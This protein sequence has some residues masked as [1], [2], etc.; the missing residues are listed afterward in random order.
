MADPADHALQGVDHIA[1]ATRD[2]ARSL[3]FFRDRLGLVVVHDETLE[4][5][6]VRLVMLEGGGTQIQLVQPMGPG[7]VAA[8]LD[9]SGE[10]LHH[11]CFRVRRIEDSVAALG[12]AI[13]G[14][15][16]IGAHG[17]PSCFLDEPASGTVVELTELAARALPS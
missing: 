17:R 5:P 15:V 3:G 7:R 16:F 14:E 6:P 11:V 9:E 1:I 13:D 8:F 12:V 10:G 4:R 2:A